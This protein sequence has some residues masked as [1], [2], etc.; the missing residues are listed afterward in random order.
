MKFHKSAI[1]GGLLLEA[2]VV[3]NDIQSIADLV[4]FAIKNGI[5]SI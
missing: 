5:V 2:L 1:K 4:H 3:S